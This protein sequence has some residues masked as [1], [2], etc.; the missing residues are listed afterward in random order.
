MHKEADVMQMS[1]FGGDTTE[2][3]GC[4]SLLFLFYIDKKHEK[5]EFI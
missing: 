5:E 2:S 4:V 1:V 3:R